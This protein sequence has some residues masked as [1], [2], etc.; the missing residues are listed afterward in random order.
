MSVFQIVSVCVAGAVAVAYLMPL[1][2]VSKSDPMLTHLK[3]VISIR[4]QYKTEA[5]TA[6]CNAL[7]QTLLGTTK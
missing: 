7:I 6:A 1:L 2:P 3:N 4:E 5:V